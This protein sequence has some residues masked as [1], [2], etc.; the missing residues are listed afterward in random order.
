MEVVI[1]A[2]LTQKEFEDL[3]FDEVEDFE[4][5]EKRASHA[6]NLYCRNRYDYKDLK[7]RNSPSAKGCKAGNRLSDSIFK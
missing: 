1:I 6:V 3:G 5:M 2:F 7:K 4:K